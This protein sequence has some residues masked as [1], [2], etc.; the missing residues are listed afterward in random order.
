MSFQGGKSLRGLRIGMKTWNPGRPLPPLR[1]AP[2]PSC[3]CTLV[4]AWVGSPTGRDWLC[5]LTVSA[6]A[7]HS[8]CSAN[9]YGVRKQERKGRRAKEGKDQNTRRDHAVPEAWARCLNVSVLQNQS[10]TSTDESLNP[11][12]LFMEVD[13]RARLE[14]NPTR[15]KTMA[16]INCRD[17]DPPF[18]CER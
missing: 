16:H 12:G 17:K 15:A 13:D 4:S 3:P 2:H 10:R 9:G 18:S 5:L 11:I 6:E 8:R 7:G 14:D 1:R